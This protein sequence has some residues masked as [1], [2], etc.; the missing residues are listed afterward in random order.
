MTSDELRERVLRNVQQTPAP[1]RSQRVVRGW[2]LLAAAVLVGAASALIGRADSER[3][4]SYV[5]TIALSAATAALWATRAAVQGATLNALTPK[6]L[7]KALGTTPALAAAVAAVTWLTLE[8]P[9]MPTTWMADAMCAV[10]HGMISAMLMTLCLLWLRRSDP[11]SPMTRGALAGLAAGAW[12]TLV[13]VLRCPSVAI[14]HVVFGH[15]LPI[16][17][18]VIAGALLGTRTVGFRASR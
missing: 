11:W 17:V 10:M 18:F 1:T 9:P 15:V 4:L 16:A 6:H 14:D 12:G 5:L 7:A 3:P 13:M 8:T 2:S